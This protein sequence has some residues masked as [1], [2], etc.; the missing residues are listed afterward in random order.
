MPV[1]FM[2]QGH[3]GTLQFVFCSAGISQPQTAEHNA[4]GNHSSGQHDASQVDFSCPFA[5]VAAAPL[6]DL[7]GS[8]TIPF[9][10]T[11]EILPPAESPYYAAGPPRLDLARGPPAHS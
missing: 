4:A 8:E 2:A 10:A 11:A 5:Q 3:G 7:S 9:I 1:G 6:L